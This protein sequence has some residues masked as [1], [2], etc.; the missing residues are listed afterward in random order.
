[1][2]GFDIFK[3]LEEFSEMTLI[4]AATIKDDRIRLEVFVKGELNEV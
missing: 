1:M 2:V 3:K 4:F